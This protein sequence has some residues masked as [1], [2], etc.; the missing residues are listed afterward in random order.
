MDNTRIFQA[1]QIAIAPE[2][3]SILKDYAKAMIRAQPQSKQA[4]YRNS[5]DYFDKRVEAQGAERGPAAK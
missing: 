1:E 5:L 4:L 3:A 2:L